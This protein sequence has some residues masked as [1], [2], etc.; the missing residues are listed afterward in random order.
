MRSETDDSLS[1]CSNFPEG[2]S[3]YDSDKAVLPKKENLRG[4]TSEGEFEPLRAILNWN[5]NV[6]S[7]H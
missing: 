7:N 2:S 1:S 6:F 5:E 4:K 3:S